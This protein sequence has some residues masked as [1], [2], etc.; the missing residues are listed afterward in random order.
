LKYRR[1][2]TYIIG[3]RR[4]TFAKAYRIKVRCYGEHVGERILSNGEHIGNL[5]GTHWEPGENEKKSLP[6]PPPK[7]YKEKK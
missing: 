5:M 6:T 3:E 7:I 4:K 2:P 1:G